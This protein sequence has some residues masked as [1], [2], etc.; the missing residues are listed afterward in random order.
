MALGKKPAAVAPAAARMT[1][2]QFVD[3]Y[4][5]MAAGELSRANKAGRLDAQTVHAT[6]SIAASNLALL[7]LEIHRLSQAAARASAPERGIDDPDPEPVAG[8]L[9][10]AAGLDEPAEPAEGEET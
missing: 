2:L 9:Q 1:A 10:W 8:A 6:R 7:N 3:H 5:K 4:S